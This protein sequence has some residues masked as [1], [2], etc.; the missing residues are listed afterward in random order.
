MR[1]E[2]SAD[3][4]VSHRRA[5]LRIPRTLHF[6]DDTRYFRCWFATDSRRRLHVNVRAKSA[7]SAR[8]WDLEAQLSAYHNPSICEITL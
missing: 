4:L 2:V 5:N 1:F 3:E 7:S 8:N 6:D